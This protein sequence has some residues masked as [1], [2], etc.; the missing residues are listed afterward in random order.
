MK[1]QPSASGRCPALDEYQSLVRLRLWEHAGLSVEPPN[2]SE[3]L[4]CYTAAKNSVAVETD[5]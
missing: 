3:Y 4:L 2:I 5:V 1:S